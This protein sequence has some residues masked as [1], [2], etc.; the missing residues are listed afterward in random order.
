MQKGLTLIGMP[1][2]GKSTLGIKLSKNLNREFVD[3]DDLIL[4]TTGIS[5]NKYL[6]IN[7]EK[8][9]LILEEDL[10]LK[11]TL[12]NKVYSPGG[13]I[14]YMEK[15]MKKVLS[16]TY[17]LFL[18][19]KKDI[20]KKRIKNMDTRAIIGLQ[21]YGFDKLFDLRSSLYKQYANLHVDVDNHTEDEVIKIILELLQ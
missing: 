14:V 19:V 20:L 5:P 3:L 18:Q 1:G 6:R 17:V 4:R 7:G 16:E 9:L 13:S 10:T 15:A 11:L 12:W 8:D 21:E 2:A